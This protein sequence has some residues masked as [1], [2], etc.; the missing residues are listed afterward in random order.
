ME[1]GRCTELELLHHYRTEEFISLVERQSRMFRNGKAQVGRELDEAIIAAKAA[2]ARKPKSMGRASRVPLSGLGLLLGLFRRS[3][4]RSRGDGT[5]GKLRLL[6]PWLAEFA[7]R[8][9]QSSIRYFS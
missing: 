1:W 9:R 3:H 5:R 4:D 2:I 6:P 7:P 8:N